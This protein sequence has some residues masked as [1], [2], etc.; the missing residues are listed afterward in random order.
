MMLT[1]RNILSLESTATLW[2]TSSRMVFQCKDI[3][4]SCLKKDKFAFYNTATGE[5]KYD[6]PSMIFLLFQKT[7]PSTIVRLDSILKQIENAKLGKHAND[8][9]GMLTAIEGL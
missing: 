2:L 5:V 6:G 4:T 3:P 9:D 7:D 1:T 8:V